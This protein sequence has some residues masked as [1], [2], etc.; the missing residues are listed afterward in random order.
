MIQDDKRHSSGYG[1]PQGDAKNMPM[2]G[3]GAFALPMYE[4]RVPSDSSDS[5]IESITPTSTCV[6]SPTM[7]TQD[8]HIREH[9]NPFRSPYDNPPAF[10][11]LPPRQVSTPP[12][13][14]Q[15][16]EK[17]EPTPAAGESN[18]EG[19]KKKKKRKMHPFVKGIV[20]LTALPFVMTAVGIAGAGAI[21]Y[22]SG[23]IL[24]GVGDIMMGGP[25]RKEA[26]KAWKNRKAEKR[27]E[28]G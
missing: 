10:S 16:E 27:E 11:P 20:V 5:V 6:S 8:A 22:G 18:G 24:V 17:P 15:A 7:H 3:Q 23:H 12:V 21:I 14:I 13:Q 28:R 26:Q 19:K 4:N 1:E 25:L 2:K 9:G